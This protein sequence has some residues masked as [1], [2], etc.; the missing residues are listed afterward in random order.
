MPLPNPLTAGQ[1]IRARQKFGGVTSAWSAPITV[2]DHT[3]DFPAGPPRP[4]INPAPVYECGGAPGVANLLVGSD[5]W[6]TA[7]AVEVGRVSGRRRQ[8]GVN[9]APPYAPRS[10]GGGLRIAVQRPEPTVGRSDRAAPA[11]AAAGS[12]VPS[13]LCRRAAGHDHERRQRCASH[14]Q[15]QRIVQF[16]FPSW[17]Y[18]HLVSLIRRSRRARRSR[19]RSSFARAIRRAAAGRSPC[20]PAR[21]CPLPASSRC[22]RV[23]RASRSARLCPTREI[24]VYVNGVKNGDGSGPVVQLTQAVAGGRHRRRPAG[25][26]Q[27]RRTHGAGADRP[28]RGAAARLRPFRPRPV[29][30]SA[31]RATTPG[32]S[33]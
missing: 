17:G 13:G 20:Y 12:G 15:P 26:G 1:K 23:T 27:L 21:R 4:E 32:R 10:V 8:Q 6:I 22:R 19:P 11:R 30:R 3:V 28:M 33:R 24:K 29:S 5:V 9:V 18:Q 31:P 14:P 7:D 2:G 25:A 16:S